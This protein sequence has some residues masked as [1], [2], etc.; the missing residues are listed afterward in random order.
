MKQGRKEKT[1]TKKAWHIKNSKCQR[2]IQ[3]IKQ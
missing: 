2:L 3:S 1:G